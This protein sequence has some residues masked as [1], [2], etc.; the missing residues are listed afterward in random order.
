MLSKKQLTD[1][2]LAFGR[3]HKCCR[4]L[5]QDE[6][7]YG[8]YFCMKKSPKKTQID[9]ELE[10]FV[11]EAKKKGKD[12]KKDNLPLGDNCGGYPILRYIEQGYD[13]KT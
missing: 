10:D 12:P 11:R 3:N 8:K 13:Q 7:E 5:A 1:V 6:T 4:Y 2:C 9:V